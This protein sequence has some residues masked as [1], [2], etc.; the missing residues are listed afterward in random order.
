MA[1][2]ARSSDTKSRKYI[3]TKESLT[4]LDPQERALKFKYRITNIRNTYINKNKAMPPKYYT[5]QMEFFNFAKEG[6]TYARELS[7]WYAKMVGANAPKS[8]RGKGGKGLII[9]KPI[10][11]GG[12]KTARKTIQKD[13]D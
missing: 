4:A 12:A 6:D 2:T 8:G 7:N 1:R 9:P 13:T 11:K 3:K 5:K 10:G